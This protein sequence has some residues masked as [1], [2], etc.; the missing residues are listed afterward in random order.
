MDQCISIGHSE[1]LLP[2]KHKETQGKTKRRS[3]RRGGSVDQ[4]SLS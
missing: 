1:S 3:S 4:K 2:T